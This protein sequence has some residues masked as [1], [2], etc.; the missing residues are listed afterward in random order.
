MCCCAEHELDTEKRLR[1]GVN[2]RVLLLEQESHCP[3]CPTDFANAT[4]FIVVIVAGGNS[5]RQ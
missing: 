5:W 2:Q 3:S 1:E 4:A